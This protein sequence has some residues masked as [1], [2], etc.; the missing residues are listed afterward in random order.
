MGSRAGRAVLG[1]GA[2]HG[3]GSELVLG[4]FAWS[5]HSYGAW[6]GSSL[7]AR[8]MQHQRVYQRST[9]GDNGRVS[10][11]RPRRASAEGCR[12]SDQCA[13]KQLSGYLL[14]LLKNILIPFSMKHIL[15]LIHD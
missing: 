12:L 11:G 15:L 8:V 6:Y 5:G 1:V 10:R 13:C 14:S 2:W 4:T 3:S 7:G 9:R